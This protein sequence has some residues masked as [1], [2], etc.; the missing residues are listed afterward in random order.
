MVNKHMKRHSTSLII[1]EMQIK[2]TMRYHFTPVRM[3]IIKKNT[4]NTSGEDTKKRES[5]YACGGSANWFSHCGK[6][7]RGFSKTKNRTTI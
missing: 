4:N 2:T 7:N 5:S 3:A 6:Q 1:M